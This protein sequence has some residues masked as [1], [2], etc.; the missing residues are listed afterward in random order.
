M[1][2]FE[3]LANRAEMVIT[4]PR[5]NLV[6]PRLA[7]GATAPGGTRTR[8]PVLPRGGAGRYLPGGRF[9]AVQLTQCQ[10]LCTFG[11]NVHFFPCFTE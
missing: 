9:G 11:M 1:D 5:W 10:M 3:L 8:T 4:Y 2:F 7:P 6:A